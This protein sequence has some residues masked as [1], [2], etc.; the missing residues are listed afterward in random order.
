MASFR[1]QRER[2]WKI[3]PRCEN[4][5]VVTVLPEH[6]EGERHSGAL[7]IVPDNMATIQHKY[8]R[9]HPLRHHANGTNER[10]HL[11]WCYKCNKEFNELYENKL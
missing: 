8:S 10:R 1:K 6:V 2:L 9:N 11:L 5:A 7:K 4:C 3:D